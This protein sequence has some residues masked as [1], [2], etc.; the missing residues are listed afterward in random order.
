LYIEIKGERREV[1]QFLEMVF[2][3]SSTRLSDLEAWMGLYSVV[4]RGETT[5]V[6][7]ISEA[8][9]SFGGL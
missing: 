2:E 1:A 6:R 4:S 5:A 8:S 7:F 3:T 9:S